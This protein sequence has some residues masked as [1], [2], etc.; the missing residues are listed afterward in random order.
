MSESIYKE[1]GE[2]LRR[3]DEPSVDRALAL[4]KDLCAKRSDDAKAWFEYAGAFDFLG[5]EAEALPHYER[6]LALG[7]EALPIE[8]R[9]RLFIQYGST[10]RNLKK[11][12]RSREI[13]REGIAKFP[14]VAAL[15]AFL[16]LVEYSDGNHAEAARLFLSAGL[17]S[18]GDR[19]MSDYSRAL[20][21]YL[22]E[23]G[24]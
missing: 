13:L 18:A 22:G 23:L 8:D 20:R 7:L 4:L 1:A 17:P 15:K 10:L 2:L 12:H 6:A 9:P 19:S 11:Y 24:G 16:G 5:R 3:G 21:Y 14:D